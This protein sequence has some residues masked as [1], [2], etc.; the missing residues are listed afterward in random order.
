M[1]TQRLTLAASLGLPALLLVLVLALLS[2]C[3][4]PLTQTEADGKDLYE[5][6]CYECHDENQ[7]ELKTPPPKLHQLFAK[8]TL[9]DGVTP[10]TDDAVR[11]VIRYGKR[12]MPASNGLLGDEQ[13][14]D[15][16]AYLHRK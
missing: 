14:A 9:P 1:T 16:V 15:I 6:H 3:D 4:K 7:L 11:R 12:T 2:S 13:I 5:L 10:A 8:S